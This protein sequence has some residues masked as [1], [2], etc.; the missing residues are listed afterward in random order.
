MQSSARRPP[1]RRTLR[2]TC[3]RC[4]AVLELQRM[5]EHLRGSHHLESAELEG[6]LLLA[7]RDALRGP[8]HGRS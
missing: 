4:Q 8:S 2:T 7:R 6:V 3:P 5:R 1:S